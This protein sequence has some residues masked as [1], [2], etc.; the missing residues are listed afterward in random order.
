MRDPQFRQ[1]QFDDLRAPHIAPV[2]AL[3]DE[4]TDPAGRGW[5]PYVAPVY[6]GVDARVLCIQRDPGPKTHSGLGG[7]GF[8]CL[9]NDDATAE[10][11]ATCW[12][13]PAYQSARRSR[14]TPTPGIS[15]ARRE[16]PNSRP[17]P[18]HFGGSSSFSPGCA[19]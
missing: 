4:L 6:G 10:R 13:R 15:T 5:V 7:S 11:F 3:V 8:L 12:R 2:N 17:A 16:P 9:E 19:W 14:G 18:S 1:Q